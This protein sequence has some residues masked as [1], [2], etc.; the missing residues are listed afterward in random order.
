MSQ[1]WQHFLNNG[2]TPSDAPNDSPVPHENEA[3]D[4]YS[5]V[6]VGISEKLRPA[7]VNLNCGSGRRQSA[8][9][10]VLFTP[11]GFLLTNHH[12]VQDHD[13]FPAGSS[14]MTRGRTWLSFKPITSERFRL[15]S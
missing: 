12:V 8:G 10:G 9:S 3:F 14:A 5:K 15:P 2:P 7:V 13:S 11:D 4:A 1:F 6:V